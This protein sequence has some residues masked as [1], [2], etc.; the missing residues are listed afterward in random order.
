MIQPTSPGRGS[1][2]SQA[3]RTPPTPSRYVWRKTEPD[4]KPTPREGKYRPP[5]KEHRHLEPPTLRETCGGRFGSQ[6]HAKHG[7]SSCDQC[8]A[9]K[10]AYKQELEQRKA[11]Q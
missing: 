4:A 7:E 9:S 3:N 5:K 2:A 1:T 6:T 10:A 8:K 11:R